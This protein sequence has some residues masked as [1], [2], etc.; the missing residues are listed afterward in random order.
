LDK[1]VGDSTDPVRTVGPLAPLFWTNKETIL[2]VFSFITE[3]PATTIYEF[4][5]STLETAGV[6][7]KGHTEVVRGLALS[8]DSALVASASGDDTIKLWAFESRQLLASFHVLYPAFLI[9]SPDTHILTYTTRSDFNIYICNTPSNVL[10]VIGPAAEERSTQQRVRLHPPSPTFCVITF[11]RRRVEPPNI[12][13]M[14]A[15]HPL[16][17]VHAD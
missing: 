15:S 16:S 6:P 11:Y 7:F 10:A 12:Y 1:R 14:Y 5:A 9:F 2:A 4:N 8:F 3:E 17:K 13:W